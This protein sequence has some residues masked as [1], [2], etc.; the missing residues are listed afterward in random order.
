MTLSSELIA[1]SLPVASVDWSGSVLPGAA[2]EGYVVKLNSAAV[3]SKPT[4]DD[5]GYAAIVARE[6]SLLKARG[7]RID[8]VALRCV[9]SSGVVV[10][11]VDRAVDSQVPPEPLASS[12]MERLRSGIGIGLSE[13]VQSPLLSS[14][15]VR[16]TQA[17]DGTRTATAT[18]EIDPSSFYTLVDQDE[19]LSKAVTGMG[20]AAQSTGLPVHEYLVELV[21]ASGSL[22][23]RFRDFYDGNGLEVSRSAQFAPGFWPK[24]WRIHSGGRS[25][26]P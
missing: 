2:T 12:D 3:D 24:D 11:A 19:V 18:Y 5:G 7:L 25:H 23:A 15:K 17:P 26:G 16:V 13:A 8:A 21:D 22:L 6:A 20:T 9:N 4:V 14:A 1:Q 10:S